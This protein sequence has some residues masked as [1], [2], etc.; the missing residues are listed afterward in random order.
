M[1]L[2]VVQASMVDHLQDGDWP[3][4]RPAVLDG[5]SDPPQGEVKDD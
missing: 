5:L 1:E 4:L 2:L 3:T